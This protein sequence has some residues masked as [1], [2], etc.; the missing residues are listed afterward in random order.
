MD[1]KALELALVTLRVNKEDQESV[2]VF[3]CY[4]KIVNGIFYIL[5][6]SV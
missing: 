6:I 5:E 2:N 1:K 4:K 3:K